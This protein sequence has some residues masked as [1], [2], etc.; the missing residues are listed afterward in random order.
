MLVHNTENRK[1]AL[2]HSRHKAEIG[3]FCEQASFIF[4][5][6]RRRLTN[7]EVIIGAFCLVV[8]SGCMSAEYSFKPLPSDQTCIALWEGPQVNTDVACGLEF[9]EVTV[10]KLSEVALFW[11]T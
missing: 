10:L 4:S 8:K 1:C 2:L 6:Y 7:S 11:G 9:T 3:H 5:Y